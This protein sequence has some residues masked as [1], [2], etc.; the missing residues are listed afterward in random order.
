MKAVKNL[1]KRGGFSL[2]ETL[3]AILILLMVSAI[4]AAGVPVARDAYEKVVLSANAQTMLSS[5][6]SALRDELGT[7]WDVRVEDTSTKTSGAWL[8][9]YSSSTG[10][11]TKLY[12]G[13]YTVG[14]ETFTTILVQD[15]VQELSLGTVGLGTPR[16]LV[17]DSNKGG[18]GALYVTCDGTI[19]YANGTVTFTNLKVLTAGGTELALL[20]SL[21]IKVA[22]ASTGG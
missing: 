4:V 15:N 8:T 1:K 14:G 18:M 11:R 5:A 16:Q 20:P 7:A 9:Y 10:A 12:L 13:D 19:G 2:A 17:Q 22:S 3:V 21:K 6:V